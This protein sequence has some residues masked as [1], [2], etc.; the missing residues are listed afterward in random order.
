MKSRRLSRYGTVLAAG[1]GTATIEVQGA[2]SGCSRTGCMGRREVSPVS[3][4][5]LNS[6]PGQQVR[7]SVAASR[8]THASFA[9][10]G[11]L[12]ALALLVP[13]L[14]AGVPAVFATI[15]PFGP[16][17]FG[18]GMVGALILGGWLARKVA[19][20]LDLQVVADPATPTVE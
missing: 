14:T 11:P 7:L 6:V 18:C 1:D 8:L 13:G 5:G 2:C 20:G 9:A 15:Q 17:L 4:S 10:F 12:L 16:A 19:G 3:V